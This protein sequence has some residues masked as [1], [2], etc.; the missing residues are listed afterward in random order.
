MEKIYHAVFR[1]YKC[2]IVNWR[3]LKTISNGTLKWL[4]NSEY[5][6]WVTTS[7]LHIQV[8]VKHLSAYQCT[9]SYLFVPL[10]LH[11]ISIV[12]YTEEDLWLKK[13]YFIFYYTG[14][15]SASRRW[16]WG[17]ENQ[18]C[19]GQAFDLGIIYGWNRGFGHFT[20]SALC[21]GVALT[22]KET[23]MSTD[24]WKQTQVGFLIN[25]NA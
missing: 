3:R 8:V 9:L 4:K 11:C 19:L 23:I 22:I 25:D 14:Q 20:H 5:Y 13:S 1:K 16:H 24:Q 10:P 15:V 21:F 7:Q 12:Y 17:S 2:K 18:Y 6:I